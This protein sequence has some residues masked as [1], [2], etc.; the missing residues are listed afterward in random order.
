MNDPY[1]NNVNQQMTEGGEYTYTQDGGGQDGYPYQTDYPPQDED[2]ASDATEGADEDDQ[3][4]EGE[5]QGIPHPDEIKEARRAA[6]LEARRK[7]RMAAEQE[8]EED[9]LPE[10][11]ETIM[12][13]CGHGRFQ[14]M[15][16]FVLG[17]ALM[18]DGVD[19]FVVG[20]VMPSAEK[21]MCISNSDKGLLG[22]W[23]ERK[24]SWGFWS[25]GD[26]KVCQMWKCGLFTHLERSKNCMLNDGHSPSANAILAC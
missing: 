18:A 8:E 10:Q 6:R 14:W 15:L 12:E 17:L 1:Q 26:L 13:D 3:M 9:N 20:F 19:S 4:Y 7:A 5:Y 22:K 25:P 21:D 23:R 2:A 16:F 24:T 11:Y